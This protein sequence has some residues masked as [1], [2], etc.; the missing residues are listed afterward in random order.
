MSSDSIPM[1][2][3]EG[4][5]LPPGVHVVQTTRAGGVSEGPWASLNLASHTGDAP[6]RVTENRRRLQQALGLA[7]P[8]A[9]PRQV[10]G[11][12]VV[13]AEALAAHP[14]DSVEADAVMATAPGRVCAVQTADCL[15][16]VLVAD[17]G[18]AVAAVH[19][20][21][22]GL[23]GGILEATVASLQAERPEAGLLAWMGAAI[24][25]EAFEVGPEVRE[26][27]LEG[28]A[29]AASAFHPGRDGRY[30]ADIYALARR[31][32]ERAGI[33]QV[34]GGGRCTFAEEAVFYSYRRDGTTGRMA[35]LVWIDGT[36]AG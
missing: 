31:R 11:G 23:A 4:L 12:N 1:L 26:A 14:A 10:H 19:A 21:W 17:S 9:W 32:L 30:L 25:P 7:G 24:G 15:P 8:V 2:Y 34:A 20:G 3:P 5:A 36:A 22:R 6:E 18:D 29:G 35:S 13:R 16:V 27:F 28:D 33:A